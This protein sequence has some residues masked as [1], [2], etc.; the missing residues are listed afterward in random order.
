LAEWARQF[1]LPADYRR[2]GLRLVHLDANVVQVPG[3]RR[4][5]G[6]VAGCPGSAEPSWIF[7]KDFGGCLGSWWMWI[8]SWSLEH[9]DFM[10]HF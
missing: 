6:R 4:L 7:W 2:A 10:K 5:C 8:H 3:A 1:R 9:M